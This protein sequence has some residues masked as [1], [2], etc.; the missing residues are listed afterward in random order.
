METL[1][2]HKVYNIKPHP[3]VGQIL[4]V[5]SFCGM[6]EK[7]H[8]FFIVKL[9]KKVTL[10]LITTSLGTAMASGIF[11]ADDNNESLFLAGCAIGTALHTVK[12]IYILT[13]KQ[14]ILSFIDDICAHSFSDFDEFGKVQQKLNTFA[15]FGYATVFFASCG[16]V[17]F[18]ILSLPIFSSEVTLPLNVGFPLDWKHSRINYWLAH[19]FI[20]I[21][22]IVVAVVTFF[23]VIY[24]YILFNCSI[25]YT[26]LGNQLRT[27]G[28]R[29]AAIIGTGHKISPMEQEK[30]IS[31]YYVQFIESHQNIQK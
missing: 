29:T 2:H 9:F 23:T 31:Q 15:K 28:D 8:Q 14:Q 12:L 24:W 1:P 27:M 25:K 21:G 7:D 13:K 3:I 10:F 11:I 20:S 4:A 22:V 5:F 16:I 30:L 19:S 18:L 26:I 17:G 6:W